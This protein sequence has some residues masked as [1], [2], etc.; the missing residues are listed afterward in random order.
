[1][2]NN[3]LRNVG[4]LLA[5]DFRHLRWQIGMLYLL[6]TFVWFDFHHGNPISGL[7]LL[8]NFAYGIAGA[9]L[10]IFGMRSDAPNNSSAWWATRPISPTANFVAKLALIVFGF[11]LPLTLTTIGVGIDYQLPWPTSLRAAIEVSLWCIA[12]SGTVATVQ[13][14]SANPI[15]RSVLGT[16]V[17]YAS[18]IVFSRATFYSRQPSRLSTDH[19]ALLAEIPQRDLTNGLLLLA[20]GAL[21]AWWVCLRLKGTHKA[22]AVS[23]ISGGLLF[24]HMGVD[25]GIRNLSPKTILPPARLQEIKF[26]MPPEPTRLPRKE[27]SSQLYN[28]FI[29]QGLHTNEFVALNSIKATFNWPDG[30]IGEVQD[31]IPFPGTH[32][33][34]IDDKIQ[35][36]LQPALS[37][38]FPPETSWRTDWHH[39]RTTVFPI[40]HPDQRVS[41]TG[42]LRGDFEGTL[43]A[44]IF[45]LNR[46]GNI[47]FQ[48]G[49]YP[50]G[51]GR[52][53]RI[54]KINQLSDAVQIDFSLFRTRLALSDQPEGNLFTPYPHDQ[55]RFVFVIYNPNE[56]EAFLLENRN[57]HRNS[58]GRG[59][60][61]FG[62][63]AYS[64]Q[65]PYASL[66]SVFSGR[67]KAD[68][69][70]ETRLLVFRID[71]IG[72]MRNEFS[73]RDFPVH[74]NVNTEPV[75]FVQT[76]ESP[77]LKE[78]ASEQEAETFIQQVLAQSPLHPTRSSV[79]RIQEQLGKLSAKHLPVLL[80]NLP[81]DEGDAN[82][83]CQRLV[84]RL[85]RPE[86]LP[87]FET[88]WANRDLFIAQARRMKWEE[89]IRETLAHRL[90]KRMPMSP[91]AIAIVAEGDDPNIAPDLEWHFLNSRWGQAEI[92]RAL[93][94][95]EHLD[96]QKLVRSAWKRARVGLISKPR[97]A[98]AAAEQGLP[99]ALGETARY[100]ETLEGDQ[101]NKYTDRLM[102]LTSY[103]GDQADFATWF[104]A[105]LPKLVFDSQSGTY[106][107]KPNE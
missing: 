56:G 19:Q 4:H 80:R 71:G 2:M 62:R 66:K 46:A 52:S 70:K 89:Q 105:N 9:L 93:K 45:Q 17:I 48:R 94:N 38:F 49:S 26:Q 54:T 107:V 78:D 90:K 29:F 35:T 10:V 75:A 33:Y 14:I 16:A 39:N 57:R 99:D 65:V 24:L 6:A 34:R 76:Q 106:G 27:Q 98:L 60:L 84:T 7:S 73:A 36:Q 85:I 95:N 86:H 15:S 104:T 88:L 31:F 18:L 23:G 43:V 64:F 68:W 47:P 51:A 83:Y 97:L 13:N 53:V 91:T 3:P 61:P 74:R 42:E 20:I 25:A 58:Q 102:R 63:T 72:T 28:H 81:E 41:Y 103:K 59:M 92:L 11:V 37:K 69:I 32:R 100:W 79:E 82:S 1:M 8:L 44:S 22:L 21:F 30:A 87:A 96:Q 5:K 77:E 67:T 101:R 40:S 55:T 50:L 12:L